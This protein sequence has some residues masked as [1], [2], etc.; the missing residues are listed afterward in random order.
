VPREVVEQQMTTNGQQR[1]VLFVHLAAARNGAAVALLHFLRWL[2]RSGNRPF[3]ILLSESGE[4][5]SE[6]AA[7]GNTWLA[8]KSRW[9]PGGLRSQVASAAGLE[10][11]ARAAEKADLR[12]FAAGCHPALIYLNGFASA[13]FRLIE[14]LDL[15]VPILTHVHELGLLFRAQAGSATPRMLSRTRRFIACSGAVKTNLVREHGVESARI[16]VVHASISV[17]DVHAQRSRE[18]VLRELA[19]PIDALVVIGCGAMGW[20][21]GTD[22]FVRLAQAVCKQRDRARFV[23]VGDAGGWLIAQHEHDIAMTGLANKVRFTGAVDRPADY[24]SAADVF[25]LPSREDSFPLACL[26]AAALG[27]PIVCF[28]DSG[29]MP[30]FVEEDAGFIVP[31]LDVET[32]TDRLVA[33]LDSSECRRILGATA[34]RKVAERHD[35]TTAA[36]RIASIIENT[37]AEA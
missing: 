16:D 17:G 13:N 33:L 1:G 10:R 26:E 4:L 18:D 12:S 27:K 2:N 21:K 7:V 14:V 35:V 22:I 34:R 8:G 6:F 36:P 29:G 31:N 32:M 23:W 19:F 25:V 9:C 3:S 5:L 20:N 30:E 28:A 15:G 11:L 37:I 24:L